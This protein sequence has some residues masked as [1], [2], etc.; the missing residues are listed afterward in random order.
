MAYRLVFLVLTMVFMA[1]G[2]G[3]KTTEKP[4]ADAAAGPNAVTDGGQSADTSSQDASKGGAVDTTVTTGDVTGGDVVAGKKCPSSSSAPLGTAGPGKSFITYVKSELG[5]VAIRVTLP[6]KARYVDHTA[7]VVNVATFFTKTQPFYKDLDATKVGLI[8]V[9]Y[10]WP[11]AEDPQTGSCSEGVFDHGGPTSIASLRDV[12][13]YALGELKDIEGKLIAERVQGMKPGH[14]GLWAFSHPGIAA[15]NV[16]SNHG[17]DLKNVAWL[18]GRENPTQDQ[19]CAVELGHFEGKGIKVLNP[20][21]DYKKHYNPGLYALDLSSARWAADYVE[22]GHENEVGRAYFDIDGD[23]LDQDAD[24]ILSFRVPTMWGKRYLSRSLTH[25]LRNN[26]LTAEAWPKDLATPEEADAAWTYRNSIDRYPS[27]KG[28]GLRVMLVFAE[29]QHVQP[30]DDAAS[31]HSAYDG[32]TAAGLWVRINPDK[33]YADWALGS[34][35]VGFPDHDAQSEPSDWSKAGGSWGYPKPGG[36]PSATLGE[37]V[38]WAA[39]AEM[40]DRHEKG[41]WD[42]NLDAVLMPQVPSPKA[43]QPALDNE[44]P[45]KP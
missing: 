31:V 41:Q 40:A 35:F 15:V 12:V 34:D 32:Y 44:P 8:H 19:H 18:V 22:Q 38:G 7:V 11:G 5:N 21:Y 9:S 13:R 24:H 16:L 36:K 43:G 27:L 45:K 30:L 25:A 23:G 37:M 20:L 29:A 17:D 14:V 3:D 2:C 4:S 26:G 42:A 33:A 6:K 1:T 28:S 39:V 10:I